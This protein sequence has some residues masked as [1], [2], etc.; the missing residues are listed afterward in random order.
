MPQAVRQ[1]GER[2]V[3]VDHSFQYLR[4]CM[5]HTFNISH[6]VLSAP[7][8]IVCIYLCSYAQVIVMLKCL[9]SDLKR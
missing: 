5:T 2:K 8:S 4:N 1:E 9:K 7:K 3:Q 6:S